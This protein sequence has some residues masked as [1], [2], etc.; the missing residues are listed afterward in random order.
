M[1]RSFAFAAVGAALW[2]AFFSPPATAAAPE[3]SVSTSRQ[4]IVY[5][6]EA[7]LRGGI[8]DLAERTKKNALG[9]LRQS[10][11]W[12][13]PIVVHVQR[14][15]VNVPE[16]APARLYFSQTGFGLKIQL[17]L[18]ISGAATAP[19]LER[20]LLRAILLERMYR[21]QPDTAAGTHYVEPPD[22]LLDGTLALTRDADSAASNGGLA[23]VIATTAPMPLQAFLQQQPAL[24]DA[25]SRALY[26]AYS[27]AVL[28][29]LI[30]SAAGP[31]RLQ[32]F[33]TGL[34]GDSK[35][36]ITSLRSHFPALGNT[37]E[38]VEKNWA[39]AVV[40]FAGR[41]RYRMLG[42]E[43]TERRLAQ[44]L[45][46]EIQKPGQPSAVYAL[47]E[48]PMFL[49]ER[50][51]TA[52]LKRLT[53]ELLLLS[54]RANPL[55]RPVIGEYQQITSSIVRHKTK[56]LPERL[57]ELRETREQIG[58]RMTAIEDYM[59]WFEATQARATSGAFSD[60]MKAAETA[61]Q[62]EP[63]RRDPLSVYL[64]ALEAQLPN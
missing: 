47:D 16:A 25:P 43:E 19:A 6:S 49:R 39:A 10:D 54:G 15:L 18:T 4:F 62:R 11:G 52:G 29:M 17:D 35:D 37:A 5:G 44:A 32:K 57:A 2:A 8:C 14:P 30:E 61:A 34:R 26:Q 9:L 50:G 63:R 22:W 41:E 38:E 27:A 45:K 7:S 53:E 55:Y 24:L 46:V 31:T 1:R 28:S 40:R 21:D 48:F 64:D 56:R 3:R 23:S 13:V 58:R 42:C 51:A 33:I 20:E 36:S 60:Y 12:Q 59:N